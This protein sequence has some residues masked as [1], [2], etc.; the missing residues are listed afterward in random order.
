MSDARAITMQREQ[1]NATIHV[2]IGTRYNPGKFTFISLTF[3]RNHKASYQGLSSLFCFRSVSSS[4]F[5]IILSRRSFSH[6]FGA[7][8]PF[9]QTAPSYHAHLHLKVEASCNSL[10][11]TEKHVSYV[12]EDLRKRKAPNNSSLYLL[13]DSLS[14]VLPE[15]AGLSPVTISLLA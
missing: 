2:F 4:T 7:R 13:P 3:T 15:P 1:Y 5:I 9:L 11:Y 14:R 8:S 12:F 6:S 10:C